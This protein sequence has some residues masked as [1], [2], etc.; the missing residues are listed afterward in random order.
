MSRPAHAI[1]PKILLSFQ[2]PADGKLKENANDTKQ[3]L[4]KLLNVRFLSILAGC[5]D[6][7]A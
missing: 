6:V 5:A 2:N 4:G 3:C 7:Y 1:A